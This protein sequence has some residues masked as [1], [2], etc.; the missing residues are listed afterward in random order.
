MK[1]KLL[2][3]AVMAGLLFS[4]AVSGWALP[5]RQHRVRGVVESV[6]WAGRQMTLKPAGGAPALVLAWNDRTR[7]SQASGCANCSL[8][9]G[10]TISIYYRQ[11][12]GQKVL[13]EVGS[14]SG[15]CIQ[16]QR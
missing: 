13:R 10:R 8:G 7:F 1:T 11:E 9:V 12:V 16:G 14:G 2:P 3:S 5:P 15:A 6:D 4:M